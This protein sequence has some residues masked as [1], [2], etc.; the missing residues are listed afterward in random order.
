MARYERQSPTAIV[1]SLILI[2]LISVAVVDIINGLVAVMLVSMAAAV[3]AF[4]ALFPGSGFV[5]IAFA[6]FIAV[7]ACIFVF[8]TEANF[9]RADIAVV[10][11]GFVL[12]IFAFLLGAWRRRGAIRAIVTADHLRGEGQ[13]G[14]ALLWLAPVFGIGAFSFLVP[15]YQLGPVASDVAFLVAM[16]CIS[17]IVLFVSSDVS[18]FLLDTGLL[19]EEFFGRIT[20]LVIPAFAFLTFY[21]LLVIVFGA[22]YRILDH[23]SPDML[24]RIN[25][26]LHKISF[27]EALYFSIVTLS[28]VGYG[29]ILPASNII[30]I[31]VA[32]QI[33]CGV[34]LLLFGFSEIIA[35]TRDRR[36]GRGSE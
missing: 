7:Y 32:V 4:Y 30:R 23:I 20:R 34:L 33:V 19:F 17:V 16:T 27:P 5:A 31:V 2:F 18:T 13:F 8:F 35:Y 3:G 14:H 1:F 6:N 15:A 25:G 9:I 22:I 12:P 28:T 21:S 29:D 10:L 36:G 26:A 11:L 24:F